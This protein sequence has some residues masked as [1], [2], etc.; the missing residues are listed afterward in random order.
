MPGTT[1]AYES[2]RLCGRNCGAKRNTGETGF[3]GASSR[4]RLAWAGLHYGEEPIISGSGGSGAVFVSGCSL[5][6]FFCQNHELSLAGGGRDCEPREFADICLMLQRRGA[7]NINIVT[8]THFIPSLAEGIK[9]ARKRGLRL[10]VVWNSSGY[11]S[12]AGLSLLEDFVDIYLPDL[13]VL[14]PD[15]ARA[16]FGDSS[17]PDAAKKTIL[18]MASSRPLR[19]TDDSRAALA[20]GLI[21]RH[22]VLPGRGENTREL[23]SWF[24]RSLAGKAL[25]SVMFQYTPPAGKDAASLPPGE[26]TRKVSPAEYEEVLALLEELGIEDGFVQEAPGGADCLPDFSRRDAFPCGIARPFWFYGDFAGGAGSP[27]AAG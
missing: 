7:E 4:L 25:L 13:K 16:I 18:A 20:S 21:V 2:C 15:L 8:G 9:S 27:R 23:L 24:A 6:C 3:C 22:L 14:D 5:K 12:P 1:D 10:P 17:Y 26:W 11:E 19:Y